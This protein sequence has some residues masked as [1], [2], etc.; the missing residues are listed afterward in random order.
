[1]G[2]PEQRTRWGTY[3]QIA[4]E[5]TEQIEDGRLPAGGPV[6]SE[7]EL[8][9]RFEVS[10]TVIRRALALLEQH[11][12][13]RVTPGVGRYVATD[14]TH[15]CPDRK[16][17]ALF[18]V[19]VDDLR[20][21][22]ASGELAEGGALPSEAELQRSYGVARATARHAYGVLEGAGLVTVARGKGRVVRATAPDRD[23]EIEVDHDPRS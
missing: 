19:I 12:L 21:R 16:E 10:R 22:I 8:G 1:M 7:A 2:E 14:R 13:V 17:A 4:V 11:G 15:L 3:R 9:H 18:Q 5:L 23:E 6:P 20:E